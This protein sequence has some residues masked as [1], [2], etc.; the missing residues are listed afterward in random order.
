MASEPQADNYDV[1]K[2]R[3]REAGSEFHSESLAARAARADD[4]AALWMLIK[5]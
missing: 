4:L 1:A 3:A 2:A 5:G